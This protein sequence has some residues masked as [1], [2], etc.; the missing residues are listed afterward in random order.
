MR[1]PQ[2]K[3]SGKKVARDTESA[4]LLE[5]YQFYWQIELVFKRLKS[6]FHYNEIPSKSDKTAKAWFYGKLLLVA[7]YETWVNENCFS[8]SAYSDSQRKRVPAAFR[9]LD[10][11][12]K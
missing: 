7:F 8:P 4:L 9:P 12:P 3:R 10:T 6:I 11:I 2:N 1:H 5:T